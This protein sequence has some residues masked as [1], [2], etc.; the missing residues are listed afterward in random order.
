M[1]P[2]QL[3]VRSFLCFMVAIIVFILMVRVSFADHRIG[4]YWEENSCGEQVAT[5]LHQRPYVHVYYGMIYL[6]GTEAHLRWHVQAYDPEVQSWLEIDRWHNILEHE[7]MQYY[8]LT[9]VLWNTERFLEYR[10]NK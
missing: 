2:H 9:K 4:D 1:K 7:D 5:I 3:L 6:P 10:N 8:M